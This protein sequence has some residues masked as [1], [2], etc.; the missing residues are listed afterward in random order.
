MKLPYSQHGVKVMSSGITLIYEIPR[1]KV[2]IT[3]G[4][5][6]FSVTLPYQYFG[7]NTQG[8]CGE[9]ILIQCPFQLMVLGQD[10]YIIC[11]LTHLAGTCNNNQN[12][13]CMLPGGKLVESCAIMADHWPAKHIYQPDCTAPVLPNS[14]PEPPITTPCRPDSI[15]D[16][17]K[18][19]YPLYNLV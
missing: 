15:C 14:T 16:M 17:I 6:G 11:L 5:T 8:H 18:S 10:S 2:I 13:D 4:I 1:L 3:F 9:N 19:R 12:D 7:R